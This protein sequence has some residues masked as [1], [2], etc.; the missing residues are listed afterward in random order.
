VNDE[1]RDWSM[2]D[3]SLR[4]R[5]VYLPSCDFTARAAS[6][7]DAGCK[8]GAE[9]VDEQNFNSVDLQCDAYFTLTLQ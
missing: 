1:S 9:S 4:V 7:S 2:L 6:L 8:L 5:V 3:M